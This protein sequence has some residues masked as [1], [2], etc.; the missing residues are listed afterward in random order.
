VT[1]QQP[2]LPLRAVADCTVSN[3]TCSRRRMTTTDPGA[4]P[5]P[6]AQQL[7]IITL[8][9]DIATWL[10]ECARGGR[11][12][13]RIRMADQLRSGAWKSMP[14][15]RTAPRDVL[16][17]RAELKQLGRQPLTDDEAAALDE[18]QRRR[19]SRDDAARRWMATLDAADLYGPVTR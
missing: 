3:H 16:L 14:Q 8:I 2:N 6:T 1:T 19:Q 15:R 18:Q 7:A 11:L 4:P 9:E 5:A 13:H 17:H 12:G 10:E